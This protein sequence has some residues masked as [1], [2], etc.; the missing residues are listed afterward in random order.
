MTKKLHKKTTQT[1]LVHQRLAELDKKL[2][3]KYS[4]ELSTSPFDKT[5]RKKYIEA[6]AAYKK[7]CRKAEAEHRKHLTKKLIE[8]GQNDPQT[9]L[10]TL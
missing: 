5:K 7:M 2:L 9:I 3:R 6:R 4:K 8:I 10:E 1:G